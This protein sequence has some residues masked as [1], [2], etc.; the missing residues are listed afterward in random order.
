MKVKKRINGID[1]VR[2]FAAIS[3]MLAHILSPVLPDTLKN[4]PLNLGLLS[5]LSRYVFTGHPAVIAFFVVSGFCI[6]YPY[7]NGTLPCFSFWLARFTRILI[8]VAIAFIFARLVGIAKFN[9]WDGFILWSIVCEL[10]YYALY[11]A[12]LFASRFFSW[13]LQFFVALLFSYFLV[14]VL[15]SDELGRANT[16]G[17]FL[18]WLVALPSWLAGCMLAERVAVG[19]CSVRGNSVVL[20]RF[21]VALTAST[22]IWLTVNTPLGVNL[23][24]NLFSLLVFFW[25]NVEI[26]AF[27]SGKIISYFE[28]IGKWSFSLYLY[29]MIIF[30][31][32]AAELSV[33][34][35]WERLMAL[36]VIMLLSYLAYLAFEKPSHYYA[37]VLFNSFSK[38]RDILIVQNNFNE[39]GVK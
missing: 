3:V 18:N 39:I 1:S 15:G 35:W 34:L 21:L 4:L 12:F 28:K 11:P 19:K 16:Y 23:T 38:R 24:L 20:W 8:P 27:S 33:N 26:N 2:A 31:F 32:L 17:P 5:D 6:H 13:R 30:R 14:F 25:L 22:S 29:H 10:F 7:V 36:P 9:F 37:R